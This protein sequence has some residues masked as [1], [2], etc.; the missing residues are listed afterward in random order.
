MNRTTAVSLFARKGYFLFCKVITVSVLFFSILIGTGTVYKA[1]EQLFDGI[2]S[3]G[4]RLVLPVF[5]AVLLCTFLALFF[6]WIDGFSQR[7]L[8]LCSGIL[9]AIL[10]VG[11]IIIFLNF[12]SVPITDAKDVLDQA[13][14]FAVTGERPISTDSPYASYFSKY[15]NNY[16]ITILLSYFFRVLIFLGIRDIYLPLEILA[17]AGIFIATLFTWLIGK[18]TGGLR[19]AVKVLTLCVLNPLYYLMILWVYTNTL[20]VPFMMAVFYFGICTFQAKNT[21][22]RIISSILT[23]VSAV[24]GFYIR[25]TVLIPVIALA[26]CAVLWCVREKRRWKV[27]LPSVLVFLLV[28]GLL[29]GAVSSFNESYFSTVSDATFPITHWLMIGSQRQEVYSL[30]DANKYTASFETKEEKSQ[31]TL[32]KMIENYRSFSPVSLVQFLYDKLIISWSYGDAGLMDG[33]LIQDTRQTSLFSWVLG[34]RSDIFSLYA[35]AFRIAAMFLIILSLSR[36]L[37]TGNLGLAW[38]LPVLTFFGAI[39]FYSFW[40]YKSVFHCPFLYYLMLIAADGGDMLAEKASAAGER[41]KNEACGTQMGAILASVLCIFCSC[42]S[43]MTGTTVTMHDWTVRCGEITGTGMLTLKKNGTALTQEFYASKPFNL[44]RLLGKSDEEALEAESGFT[45]TLLLESGEVL[46]EQEYTVSDFDSMGQLMV[47]TD[48]IVP[49]GRQ[50]YL[51]RLERNTDSSGKIYFRQIKNYYIDT[52]DGVMQI[53]SETKANDLHLWA[54]FEYSSTYLSKKTA[55]LLYGGLFLASLLCWLWLRLGENR[56]LNTTETIN[57]GV[58]MS[59]RGCS[60]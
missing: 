38:F 17:A 8:F 22:S 53:G 20:S 35:Y 6:R 10:T 55:L 11:L 40:E 4:M 12:E 60:K 36:R 28:G 59:D 34:D 7:G 26:I 51:L 13:M 42:Y 16:L 56:Y 33:R 27:F 45:V 47:Y 15:S 3:S 30:S 24:I 49:D 41:L 25:A 23:A 37:R 39:L 2:L 9:F 44:I 14:R 58:L 18:R 43:S 19:F 46:Y 48:P 50:K 29:F 57:Q 54:G 5:L 1:Q 31:A 32:Q 21:R 52:Y